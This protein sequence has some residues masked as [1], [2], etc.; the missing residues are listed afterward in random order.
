[1]MLRYDDVTLVLECVGLPEGL[2]AGLRRSIVNL[3]LS[4]EQVGALND[5]LVAHIQEQGFDQRGQV[6]ETGRR[7]EH[8]VDALNEE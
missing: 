8:I 4:D 3:D 6:T 2:V 7:L 5:A 1:M